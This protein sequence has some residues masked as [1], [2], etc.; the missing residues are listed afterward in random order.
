[1]KN[2]EKIRISTMIN[3][4]KIVVNG[5][6]FYWYVAVDKDAPDAT[7]MLALNIISEDQQFRIRYHFNQADQETRHITVLGSEFAGKNNLKPGVRRYL[8]PE[9]IPGTTV[10]NQCLKKLVSW[11]MSHKMNLVEVDENGNRISET[12]HK[13]K[14]FQVYEVVKSHLN[15]GKKLVADT[16]KKL[17]VIK[18]K[19]IN[20]VIKKNWTEL[21]KKYNVPV[22]AI[23]IK[24]KDSD[25][26]A[27]QTW[28]NY[29]IDSFIKK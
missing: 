15:G 10:T 25:V 27:L 9:W 7:C 3:A 13:E 8:S 22:N 4:Y 5:R 16:K 26:K 11:C 21:Q 23:G 17:A 19:G 14:V 20:P 1:M 24:I 18:Q 28:M 12:F 29:G 6:S 2:A